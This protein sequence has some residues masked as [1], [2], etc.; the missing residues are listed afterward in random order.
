MKSAISNHGFQ[1]VSMKIISHVFYYYVL[2]TVF[3]VCLGTIKEIVFIVVSCVLLFSQI[4]LYILIVLASR[5][6]VEFDQMIARL[7]HFVAGSTFLAAFLKQSCKL[8]HL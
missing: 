5:R 1:L 2:S 4:F 3:I 6:K 8:C 7:I